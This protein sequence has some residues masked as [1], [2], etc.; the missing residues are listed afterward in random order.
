MR[1][2]VIFFLARVM[3]AAIVDSVTRNACAMSGVARPQ[4]SRKVSAIRASWFR[5]GWQQV[6]MSLRRSSG[7]GGTSWLVMSVSA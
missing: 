6:K 4:T 7:I 3:R 5:A 1:A 2:A